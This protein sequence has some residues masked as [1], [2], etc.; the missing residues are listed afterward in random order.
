MF[1]GAAIAVSVGLYWKLPG[2]QINSGLA[3]LNSVLAVVAIYELVR[4]DLPLAL[5]GSIVAGALV[6]VFEAI[7]LVPLAAGFVTT[8]WLILL[9]HWFQAQAFDPPAAA[10]P[11]D[12]GS[13]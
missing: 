5:V 10:D 9:L 2:E 1:L 3:G 6:P 8:V 12:G 7:G 13:L 4:S 11:S